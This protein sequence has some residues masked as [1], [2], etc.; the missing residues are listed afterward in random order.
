MGRYIAM[1]RSE[2]GYANAK[3]VWAWCSR[4]SS[5]AK[6]VW[7]VVM[8]TELEGDTPGAWV[9][10]DPKTSTVV[11]GAVALQMQ[12]DALG[13]SAADIALATDNEEVSSTSFLRR[14]MAVQEARGRQYDKGDRER[15]MARVVEVF[16]TIYGTALTEYQ[17]WKFMEILKLVRG[18]NGVHEDSELDCIS[19]AALAAESRMA[20]VVK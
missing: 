5:D 12:A 2:K 10:Y 8:I 14:A 4:Q 3:D 16:N 13:R 17:G 11:E 9:E 15:S 19:Y 1:H 20:E 18:A 6:G 7:R